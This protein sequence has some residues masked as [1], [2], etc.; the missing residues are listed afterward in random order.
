MN[1]DTKEYGSR[2][3]NAYSTASMDASKWPGRPSAEFLML[4][5]QLNEAE[6]PEVALHSCRYCAS[7]IIDMRK[8]AGDSLVSAKD[9]DTGDKR[10]VGWELANSKPDIGFTSAQATMAAG[11]GCALFASLTRGLSFHPSGSGEEN[12]IQAQF[13]IHREDRATV[14]MYE[15]DLA[16]ET[17][18]I[19]VTSILGE[20]ELYAIPGKLSFGHAAL[21]TKVNKLL[22][23]QQL[24]P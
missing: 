1:V 8:E 12:P 5:H 18:S 17:A 19:S 7:I 21:S 22:Y 10:I 6:H 24:A 16:R 23:A 14:T 2:S 13:S 3:V 11:D 15:H 4:E 20:F 9:P